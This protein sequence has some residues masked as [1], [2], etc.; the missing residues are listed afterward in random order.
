VEVKNTVVGDGDGVAVTVT[1]GRLSSPSDSVSVS[2]TKGLPLITVTIRG[3]EVVDVGVGEPDIVEGTAVDVGG[4]ITGAERVEPGAKGDA[5]RGFELWGCA[6]KA[7]TLSVHC[8]T[9]LG[10]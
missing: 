9:W 2:V 1:V 10:F 4:A 5:G 8:P 6:R 7:F 3:V